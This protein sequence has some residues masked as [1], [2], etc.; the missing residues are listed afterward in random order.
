M[1]RSPTPRDLCG[2]TAPMALFL[3]FVVAHALLV[4]VPSDLTPKAALGRY[5]HLSLQGRHE[6]AFGL[7]ST[8]DRQDETLRDHART[9]PSDATDVLMASTL[10]YSM[11]EVG[12]SSTGREDECLVEV[13]VHPTFLRPFF[14]Q[15]TGLRPYVPRRFPLPSWDAPP[16]R[17]TRKSPA[18][19]SSALFH[20]VREGGRWRV[21]LGLEDTDGPQ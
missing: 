10:E 8:E 11:R 14:E 18:T 15:M 20:L 19:R 7:V 5:I 17:D 4:W 21:E 13:S 2:M 6:E 9:R 1:K 3:V 16:R 12:R